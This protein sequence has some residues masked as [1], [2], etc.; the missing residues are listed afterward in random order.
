MSPDAAGADRG[1]PIRTASPAPAEAEAA[2]YDQQDDDEDDPAECAHDVLPVGVYF[3]SETF[4]MVSSI[5]SWT[6]SVASSVLFSRLPTR[7]SR[8]PSR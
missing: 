7:S 4:S 8:L 3:L 2:E 1:P 6:A 5:L